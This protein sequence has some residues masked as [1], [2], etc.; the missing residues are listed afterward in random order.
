MPKNKHDSPD[1][2]EEKEI[3]ETERHIN[4]MNKDV[5]KNAPDKDKWG[6]DKK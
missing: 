5:P 2:K 6:K 4:K 1:P 3:R